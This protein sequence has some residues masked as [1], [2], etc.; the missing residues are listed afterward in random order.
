MNYLCPLWEGWT[1]MEIV[2][3]ARA[4]SK[5]GWFQLRILPRQ[6]CHSSRRTS[7]LSR[8]PS[9]HRRRRRRLWC[10]LQ[11]RYLNR[12]RLWNHH[13]AVRDK[14][15]RLPWMVQDPPQAQSKIT[16][17]EARDAPMLT[18]TTTLWLWHNIR[19]TQ[20]RQRTS[21]LRVV[22]IYQS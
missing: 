4:S 20:H 2:N 9:R 1:W 22:T 5:T 21:L 16:W 6:L 18:K 13:R 15:L 12:L 10:R 19:N 14:M 8:T 11:W 7:L 17:V 3:W